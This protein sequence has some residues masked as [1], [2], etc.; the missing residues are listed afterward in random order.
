MIG[1]YTLA[2]I[3]ATGEKIITKADEMLE[4]GKMTT[5]KGNTYNEYYTEDGGKTFVAINC[6]TKY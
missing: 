2:E 5:H 3:K 4:T 1:K 6:Y